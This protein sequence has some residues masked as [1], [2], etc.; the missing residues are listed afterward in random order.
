MRLKTA[1]HASAAYTEY[2]QEE[3]RI[4]KSIKYLYMSYVNETRMRE[5][6]F[7]SKVTFEL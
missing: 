4:S 2:T 7:L 6:R 1:I 3:I 5:R